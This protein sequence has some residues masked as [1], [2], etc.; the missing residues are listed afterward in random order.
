MA[1]AKNIE[2][3]A[4]GKQVFISAYIKVNSVAG[5]KEIITCSV[6]TFA[7]NKKN[8]VVEKTYY[9]KPHMDKGN[10]IAQAYEYLKTLPEFEGATDC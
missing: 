6:I 9:F 10:F 1:L 5:N 4:F 3:S 2:A 8:V 7:E